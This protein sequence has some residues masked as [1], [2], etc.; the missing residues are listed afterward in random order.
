MRTKWTVVTLL[1]LTLL[2]AQTGCRS[3]AQR[4]RDEYLTVATDP[5]RDTDTARRATAKAADLI[6]QEEYDAAEKELKKALKADLFFGPAHNNL[7]LVYF[8]QKKYY[9]AA[10]EFQYASKLMPTSD[11]PRNNMGLLMETVSRLDEAAQWYDE[12]LKVAPGS[13]EATANLA[14]TRLRQGQKDQRTRTLL[15]DVVMK[16]PRPEWTLWATR[17]LALLGSN[18]VMPVPDGQEGGTD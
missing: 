16:D 5:Q 2:A 1:G 18:T 11:N 7:G 6:D 9:L 17:Q 12:A 13:L 3:T 14:R 15:Q 8:H 10:W 4:E